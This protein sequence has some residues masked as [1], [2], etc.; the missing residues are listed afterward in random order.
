[1]YIDSGTAG[2]GKTSWRLCEFEFEGID[3]GRWMIPSY[4]RRMNGV[5]SKL[6]MESISILSRSSASQQLFRQRSSIERKD[7]SYCNLRIHTWDL[8]QCRNKARHEADYRTLFVGL[9]LWNT[10]HYWML[11]IICENR[12][13]LGSIGRLTEYQVIGRHL[14]TEASPTP[15]LY[16]MRIFAPN[17][18]VAKSRFWYFLMK[19]RKVKKASGEIV[20]LN[21]VGT[22]ETK[23]PVQIL[24]AY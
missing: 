15:K 8:S 11:V 6:I 18:V 4:E 23:L 14:P 9:I 13:W 3:P 2:C 7:C 21:V 5:A 1:M 22:D 12:Y 24:I 19:L 16:R 17:T 20:S 10:L